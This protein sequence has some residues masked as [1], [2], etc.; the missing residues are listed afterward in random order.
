MTESLGT[1]V[2]IERKEVGGKIVIDFF[3][4][5]D[6]RSIFMFLDHENQKKEEDATSS[7]EESISGEMENATSFTPDE[8]KRND[9]DSD[10]TL[11]SI[12]NFSI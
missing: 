2:Q 9:G 8:V 10:D 1:R 3:S 7:L 12:K 6:L 5:D 11:Y 4:G